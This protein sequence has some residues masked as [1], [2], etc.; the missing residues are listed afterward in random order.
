YVI[1]DLDGLLVNTEEKYMLHIQNIFD[2][3]GLR[4]TWD[5]HANQIGFSPEKSNAFFNAF[6]ADLLNKRFVLNLI[7]DEFRDMRSVKKINFSDTELMDGAREA[8][9]FLHKANFK[10]ILATNSTYG[11]LEQKIYNNIDV[12]IN[13]LFNENFLDIIYKSDDTSEVNKY[14]RVLEKH[15]LSTN[16]CLVIED[17]YF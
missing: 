4:Y 10:L 17:S 15:F 11:E 12:T 5:I 3:Y 2:R 1:I 14:K 16:E 6:L 9:H 13:K 8:I 7:S